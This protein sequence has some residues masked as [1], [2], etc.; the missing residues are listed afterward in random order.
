MYI[1]TAYLAKLFV[2]F[3]ILKISYDFLYYYLHI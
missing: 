2:L 3:L 1:A